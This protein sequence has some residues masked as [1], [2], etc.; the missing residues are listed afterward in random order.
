MRCE[1]LRGHP[2]FHEAVGLRRL[3]HQRKHLGQDYAHAAIDDHSRL[4]F[5]ELCPDER[6][7]S[8]VAFTERALAALI[9]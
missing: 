8:V 1:R 5:S 9:G 7:G 2:G 4:A 6:A 3:K